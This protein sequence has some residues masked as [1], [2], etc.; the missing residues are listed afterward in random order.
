MRIASTTSLASLVARSLVFAAASVACAFP[1][2]AQT[3]YKLIDK[4]GKVTYS[5]SPPK[6]F[7]GKVIRI[8]I[9]PNANRA[10]LGKSSGAH[11]QEPVRRRGEEVPAHKAG[12]LQ[13]AQERLDA[14]RAELA[15]A[16]DH[17]REGEI[18]RMGIVGGGTRPVPSAAYLQRISELE[19]AVKEA[20]DEVRNAEK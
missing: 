1:V 14:A 13:Q 4:D 18:Q 5:E 8:D 3:L 11:G 15:Q 19:Q 17:P 6:Y 16:R 2:A 10:S 7:D 20:E 12:T 9:D